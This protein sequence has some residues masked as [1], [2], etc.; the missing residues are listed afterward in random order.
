MKT[1]V[2]KILG[3]LRNVAIM[4][5]G[6]VCLLFYTD[7]WFCAILYNFIMIS[8]L[9]TVGQLPLVSVQVKPTIVNGNYVSL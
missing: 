9:F 6:K 7:L 2:L 1:T 8:R 5:F 4:F 3:E